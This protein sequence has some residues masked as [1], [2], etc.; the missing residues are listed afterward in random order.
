M[1]K[2]IKQQEQDLNFVRK[3]HE[4]EKNNLTN[5]EKQANDREEA[6][7]DKQIVD[8]KKKL[9]KLKNI[10]VTNYEEIAYLCLELYSLMDEHNDF[11]LKSSVEIKEKIRNINIKR[12]WDVDGPVRANDFSNLYKEIC[13]IIKNEFIN[14]K[15]KEEKFELIKKFYEKLSKKFEIGIITTNHDELL[16]KV[17]PNFYIGFGENGNFENSKIL[18]RQEWNFLYHI[19]GCVHNELKG[20]EI[21]WS[22]KPRALSNGLIG[23]HKELRDTRQRMIFQP[24]IT[25][26]NKAN[27]ILND[28][29][30]TYYTKMNELIYQS[31]GIIFIGYG[32]GDIH[33]NSCFESLWKNNSRKK[34]IILDYAKDEEDTLCRKRGAERKIWPYLKYKS[35]KLTNE[36]ADLRKNNQPLSENVKDLKKEYKFEYVDDQETPLAIWYNG[37]YEACKN[38]DKIENFFKK[39]NF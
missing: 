8:K 27:Q 22:E 10:N 38:S 3:S 19:H 2:L 20:D 6:A 13:K 12:E 39:F 14:T 32:F 23:T 4:K 5:E 29:Y 9:N 17:F 7:F 16:V 21:V 34:V 24:L 36:I 31:D 28:P 30:R 35:E 33:I 37:F 11:L 25:G 15:I 18:T 26:Y 1:K